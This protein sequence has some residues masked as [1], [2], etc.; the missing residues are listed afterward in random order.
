MTIYDLGPAIG[1][2]IVG[3]GALVSVLVGTSLYW[4]LDRFVLAQRRLR[5]RVFANLDNAYENGYFEPGEYLYGASACGVSWDL[6][7]FAEDMYEYDAATL[8]PHV[9]AWLSH[10]GL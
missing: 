1:A 8:K 3:G 4:L 9:Q 2:A 7:A 6:R 5:R 10:K